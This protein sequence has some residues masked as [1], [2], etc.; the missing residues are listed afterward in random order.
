MIGGPV[1][2][3]NVEWDYQMERFFDATSGAEL[4]SALVKAARAE[5]LKWIHKEG[6]YVRVPASECEG[7]PLKLKWVDVN[8]GEQEPKSEESHSSKRGETCKTLL[9]NS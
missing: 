6:V 4:D 3:D 9:R 5:E 8:K 7:V 1:S 2:D